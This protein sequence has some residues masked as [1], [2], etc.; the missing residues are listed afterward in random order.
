MDKDDDFPNLDGRPVMFSTT[1]SA[2]KNGYKSNLSIK[3]NDFN[4]L[5]GTIMELVK[6]MDE[7]NG[8]NE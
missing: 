2:G 1:T 7:L 5:V 8:D 4:H 3:T 6:F